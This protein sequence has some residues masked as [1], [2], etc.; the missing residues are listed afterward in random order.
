M[1]VRYRPNRQRL[2]RLRREL[3]AILPQLID[4][5]TVRVILFGSAA[6]EGVG[7]SSDLD[8]LIVREDSRPPTERVDDLYRRLNPSVA[9]DFLVYTP[10]ELAEALPTSGFLRT[11]LREGK[12][13]YD[14]SRAVA[15]TSSP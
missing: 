13:L 15:R 14:R 10:A 2:E 11:V 6:R 5:Q 8:L 4:P 9:V 1:P 7:A 3:D 12:V